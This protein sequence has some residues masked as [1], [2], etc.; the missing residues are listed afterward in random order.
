MKRL[1]IGGLSPRLDKEEILE[2]FLK[3]GRVTELKLLDGNSSIYCGQAD[4]MMLKCV[5]FGFVEY[6]TCEA[7]INAFERFSRESSLAKSTC[8]LGSSSWHVI[9]KTKQN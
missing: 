3:Y 2:E 4:S 1:Y 7:A 9:I 5:G 6:E 8:H